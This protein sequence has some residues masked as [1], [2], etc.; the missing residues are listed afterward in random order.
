MNN[1]LEALQKEISL[2]NKRIAV[3]ERKENRRQAYKYFKVLITMALLGV[4]AFGI[5]KAYDYVTNY[6]PNY[7]EEKIDEVN[8][9][10]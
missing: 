2:L 8:P 4:I 9:F 5:W 10:N 3:L 6:I 7:L 1:E